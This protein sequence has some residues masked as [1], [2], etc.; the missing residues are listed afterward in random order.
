MTELLTSRERCLRC[1]RP[2]PM[3]YCAG[4]PVVATATRVVVLQHPHERTH[5]FGTAR[6]AR[7]CLPG[8]SVHVPWAGF[9]GTLECRVDVPP[10]AIVLFP[11]ADAPLLDEL[12]AELP[13]VQRPSTLIALD[14]T[15]PHAKRLYRENPWLLRHRH[16]RLQ[17]EIQDRY[18]IRKEPRPDYMSTI[19]AIV[20]ALQCL[21]PATRGLGDL[22]GAF[23]RM[24]DRQIAHSA[25]VMRN[26]R[27]KLPRQRESRAVSRLLADP[28]LA[29]AYAESSLPGGDPTAPREL[30]HWVA[31]RDGCDTFEAIL[32]P[33]GDW[34]SPHH[35]AHMELTAADL[36]HGE[37]A[38]AA[39]ERFAA[40]LGPAPLAAW[41]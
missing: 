30:V 38:A 34:P 25:Q 13:A 18:R 23:D 17:P 20:A 26:G 5:P 9:T 28:A 24:I 21:E 37:D 3:C 40:W 39:R 32:R 36:E 11:R 22:L 15:W 14:G 27:H 10:D 12:L 2:S 8:A 4:L 1:W 16:V 33:A 19:E 6:L 31:A 35:L 41:T 29:V 7:L